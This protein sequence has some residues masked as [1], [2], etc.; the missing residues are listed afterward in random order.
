MLSNRQI[1]RRLSVRKQLGSVLS[2]T[3]AVLRSTPEIANP[4]KFRKT[5]SV[6]IFVRVLILTLLLGTKAWQLLASA[7]LNSPSHQVFVPILLTYTI[8]LLN[9]LCLRS[10]KHLKLL[11]YAQLFM[12]VCLSTVVIY[13]TGSLV[14][15]SLYLLIILGAAIV[16]GFHGAVIIAVCSSLL[17][18]L[19]VSGL[20][21]PLGA[22]DMAASTQDILGVYLSLLT[23]GLVSGYLAKQLETL[24]SLAS[25]HAK[26]LSDLTKQQKQLYDD[27][28]D[29]II[30]LDLD[31]LITGINQA[32]CSIMGLTQLD[33]T[34]FLGRDLAT[35]LQKYGIQGIEHALAKNT[36]ADTSEELTLKR[37][38]ADQEIHL[39]YLVRPLADSE[40]RETGRMFIFNDVSHV[41][42]IEERLLLHEQMTR[43]L[44]R[45]TQASLATSRD[46]QM[47]GES[48]VMQKVFSLVFRVAATNASVLI[49]G[50]S[51]TG[52][53]LIAKAIH[54][55]GERKSRPFV[56]VN[57]GAIPENL[58][59]SEL[60]GHKKGAFTGAVTDNPGLFKQAQGGTLFL[61][62]I[63]ELP[64]Q[65]QSKL[66][67]VLQEKRVR[68]V[69][70]VHDFAIDVRVLA[71]TNRDL[72]K[73]VAAS[74]F[75]EDLYY[76]LNVVNIVVPPLRDRK[77]D[78]PALVSYFIARGSS[79]KEKLPHV[80]SEA[81]QLFMS[82]SFPGNIR[83][84]ENIIEHALVLGGQAILPQHL[85]EE[86]VKGVKKGNGIA[87]PAE[88]EA[89]E[90]KIHILPIDLEKELS[91]IE[92][93]YLFLAL[94]Q[95][96]GI[97]KQA[98]T[99]LGLNFRSF[100]YRLKKYGLGGEGDESG[101]QE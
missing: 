59:E 73:E 71:A 65:L 50:E 19:F 46:V 17:Y 81:L 54:T 24:G 57:C 29:G 91:K 75:R 51:G 16:F 48:P 36:N 66:L 68:P 33:A 1:F 69:G 60:F 98:A 87:H 53:E 23:I 20:L 14:S 85:P 28:S 92:Q 7:D 9:A 79:D 56:A 63:G 6:L 49:S 22:K 84:L 45:E 37:T 80:S 31:S 78:I 10:S 41:K 13:V 32:A 77:E 52:K 26:N 3:R 97:K 61:D 94:Q 62:E 5:L 30:T 88:H 25:L 21:A 44:S 99:L 12:D 34:H 96:S 101:A 58:I 35:L 42:N 93:Q 18:A 72:R 11:G 67:R 64:V 38:D 86:V 89:P 70:D 40:S 76:R 100:R 47:I 90:T 27:I 15:I 74:R 83:E 2:R 4:E 82:Y 95:S 55:R 39:N 43:L 8:S